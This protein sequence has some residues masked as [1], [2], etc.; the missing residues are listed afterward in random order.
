MPEL[1]EVETVVRGLRPRL[2]GQ[3]ILRAE[4]RQ[5]PSHGVVKGSVSQFR[6]TLQGAAIRG[7]ERRAKY[8]LVGLDTGGTKGLH[9][10]I[11]HLGMSGQLYACQPQAERLKHTHLVVSLS[12]GE[13]VRFCDP[14]R[15]GKTLVIPSSALSDYLSKVGPDPLKISQQDFHSLMEGRKAPVKNLLLNQTLLGGVGNIYANEALFLARIHPAISAGKLTER[16]TSALH[17]ALRKV[18]L[19]AIAAN[20]TTVSDYRTSEGEPGWYQNRLRVYDR[21]GRPCPRCR[22]KIRRL[23]LIGRSAH[24]C[25]ACQLKRKKKDR[26]N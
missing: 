5:P 13:Q 26:Q 20:G 19:A 24:Y 17:K 18:L 9:T 4:I 25:P 1:P 2:I 23:V 16:Q 10:W 21:E 14:R 8:I 3:R 6:K 11:V 7:V 15:F 12:G 22:T